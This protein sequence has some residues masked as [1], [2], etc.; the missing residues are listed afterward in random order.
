MCTHPSSFKHNSMY[1][2]KKSQ[3]I[4]EQQ[5]NTHKLNAFHL[6]FMV[7]SQIYALE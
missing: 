6:V 3:K 4:F 1:L 2:Q 5:V 7:L